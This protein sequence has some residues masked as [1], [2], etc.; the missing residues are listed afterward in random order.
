[1]AGSWR[2]RAMWALP[3]PVEVDATADGAS[4]SLRVF[5]HGR[6]SDN[7]MRV[8]PLPDS[9]LQQAIGF[10]QFRKDGLI[11]LHAGYGS[12]GRGTATT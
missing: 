11:G 9:N 1:M 8:D 7:R 10:A 12:S 4:T 5:F 3:Q 6:N 2:S